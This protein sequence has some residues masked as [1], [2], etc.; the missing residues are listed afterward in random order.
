MQ[1]PNFEH[2]QPVER[3]AVEDL[4]EAL[5]RDLDG[6][7]LLLALFGSKARGDTVGAA[8]LDFLLI[9]DGE[10]REMERRLGALASSLNLEHGVLINTLSFSL[11]RWS[12]FAQRRAAFWQNVQRD[13]MLLLRSPR[14]PEG[15]VHPRPESE[16]RSPDHGPEITAYMAS[17]WQ[18][19]HTAESQFAEGKDQPVVANRAY[20]GIFYAANALL[21]TRGLQQSRHPGVLAAFRQNFVEPGLI[22]AACLSDYEDS[23]RR[24]L[25]SDY[26]MHALVNASY[27][28][29]S[30]E[31]AQRFISRVERYLSQGGYLPA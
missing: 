20:Y 31:A 14:L 7:L 1:A 2:L 12:D 15:L 16:Q 26:D 18:A 6:R 30:I 21:A 17:A 13:G 23:M 25:M 29:V 22:E 9:T 5:R 8:D 24:R 19:L 10:P 11:D 28:R 27:V 3:R 4:V